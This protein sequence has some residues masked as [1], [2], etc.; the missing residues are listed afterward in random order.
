MP[1][2]DRANGK[3]DFQCMAMPT[4]IT[5]VHIPHAA[6][7]IPAD[8]VKTFLVSD[9]RLQL[10]LLRM[11]DRY[12]EELFA[13]PARLATSIEFP[14]SRLVVDPER[15][16]DDSL[17]SM[18]QKG[19]GVLYTRTSDGDLLRREPFSQIE[20]DTLLTRFYFPHHARLS[21][22]VA[23]SIQDNQH[24]LILDGHS[25]GNAPYPHEPD[26]NPTRPQICI[27]TDKFHTPVW[28]REAAVDAFYEAGFGVSVDRPFSGAIV[29]APYYQQNKAVWSIMVE[30]NRSLYMHE[31]TGEKRRDFASVNQR[32]RSA[33]EKIVYQAEAVTA[34]S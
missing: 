16:V 31:D 5:V 7:K 13:L 22:A 1:F 18:A 26:Q 6:T 30:V 10:E 27:G 33:I 28:L 23:K 21:E 12:T 34:E 14:V 32:V 9:E 11:T 24:C 19:M 29:P 4:P 15:F 2:R 17:E 20:R 25:F 8:L 3:S